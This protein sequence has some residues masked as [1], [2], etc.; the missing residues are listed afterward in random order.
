MTGQ[1]IAKNVLIHSTSKKKVNGVRV[2]ASYT[3]AI[4]P[5]MMA[6]LEWVDK[7]E[8]YMTCDDEKITIVRAGR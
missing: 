3:A 6:K 4:S 2:P 8:V 7:E 1:I 5:A